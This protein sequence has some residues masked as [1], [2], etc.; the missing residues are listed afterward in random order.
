MY[1]EIYFWKSV[2]ALRLKSNVSINLLFWLSLLQPMVLSGG[3]GVWLLQHAY[4]VIPYL[5]TEMMLIRWLR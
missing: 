4:Y 2:C 5:L 1:T 3:K